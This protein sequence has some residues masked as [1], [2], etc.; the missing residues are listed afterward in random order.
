M[1]QSSI[2]SVA[3][4]RSISAEVGKQCQHGRAV[5]LVHDTDIEVIGQHYSLFFVIFNV[6]SVKDVDKMLCISGRDVV[7]AE[8][9]AR[10]LEVAFN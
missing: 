4:F 7:S 8:V 5:V 9:D 1:Y 2:W 3:T 6:R 10:G